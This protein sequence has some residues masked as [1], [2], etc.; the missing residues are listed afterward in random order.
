MNGAQRIT[1]GVTQSGSGTDGRFDV[2]VAQANGYGMRNLTGR[3][4]GQIRLIGWV[5]GQG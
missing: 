5:G 2:Y 4:G 3:A 1:G